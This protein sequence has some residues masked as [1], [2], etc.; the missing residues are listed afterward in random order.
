[1]PNRT[2]PARVWS[3]RSNHGAILVVGAA[4]GAG[5]STVA[6][7]LCRA[8]SRHDLTGRVR[9]TSLHG[10]FDSDSFRTAL[11]ESIAERLAE[12]ASTASRP[13]QGPGW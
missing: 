13:G 1:M 12:L 3:H 8:W 2:S 11:L 5:K 6:A 10:L 9:G 4:S 7:G